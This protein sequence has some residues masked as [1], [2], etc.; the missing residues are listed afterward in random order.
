MISMEELNPHNR[1][2]TAEQRKN[3]VKLCQALIE[4][5][6]EYG[7]ELYVN[8]GFR[9]EID[10]MRLNPTHPNSAHCAGLAA[11]IR[12]VDRKLWDWCTENIKFVA[13]QGLYLED[14]VYT[15]SWIHFQLRAP[16]SGLRIF[17]P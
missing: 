12:D 17:Q 5:Q 3:L 6:N 14:K 7:E 15:P 4:I 11:D 1:F 10:Q 9:T 16:K 13:E 8:S 2:V